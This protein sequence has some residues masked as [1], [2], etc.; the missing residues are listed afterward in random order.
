MANLIQTLI[1]KVNALTVLVN[2][3]STNAKKIDDLPGATTPL[4]GTDYFHIAQGGVSYKVAASEVGGGGT[5]SNIISYQTPIIWKGSG[6]SGLSLEVGDGVTRWWSATEFW[7]LAIYN[8]GTTTLKAS[9]TIID[10]VEGI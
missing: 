6:N 2:S 3:I 8:G 5:S 1:S 9:Y 7:K 4:S 10:S